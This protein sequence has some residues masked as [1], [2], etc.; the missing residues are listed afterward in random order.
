MAPPALKHTTFVTS[1]CKF[2]ILPW[3]I[4]FIIEIVTSWLFRS[5]PCSRL[6]I[7]SLSSHYSNT[8]KFL[9]PWLSLSLTALSTSTSPSDSWWSKDMFLDSSRMMLSSFL[10]ESSE[11]AFLKVNSSFCCP[12][13]CWMLESLLVSLLSL[14]ESFWTLRSSSF[15]VFCL[16]STQ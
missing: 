5:S 2:I 12:S 15:R 13:C 3:W 14:F 6:A 1:I 10:I 7:H 11:S 16:R 4:C 8:L 9:R